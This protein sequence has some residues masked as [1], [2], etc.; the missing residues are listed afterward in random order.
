MPSTTQI[1]YFW[2]LI[3]GLTHLVLESTYVYNC[4]T[5]YTFIR[6]DSQPPHQPPRFFLGHPD[7]LYGNAYSNNIFAPLWRNYA[8]ADSRYSGIDLTTLSLEIVTVFL[9]GPLALYVAWCVR[10]EDDERIGGRTW[11]WATVLASGEVYGGLM[12][13]LPEWLSGWQSLDTDDPLHLWFYVVF[14]NALWI[15]FPMWV[16]RRAYLEI[17]NLSD[18]GARRRNEGSTETKG[19]ASRIEEHEQED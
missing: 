1:L 16:L 2:H 7:R 5:G 15:F 10:R 8:K 4:F 14:F 13:F 12:N 19:S 9:A 17:V 11:F 6:P 3:D 18:S